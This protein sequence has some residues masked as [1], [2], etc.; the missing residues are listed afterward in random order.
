MQEP[1][2]TPDQP[3]D[4]PEALDVLQ[5]LQQPLDLSRVRRRPSPGSGTVPYLAGHDIITR[6][7]AIF[8]YAWSFEL[9]S[10]PVIER[11]QKQVMVWNTKEKRQVP[12]LD[13]AGRS[14]MER[15]G[16]VY[17]TG[18]VSVVLNGKLYTH[19]DVG[20]CPFIGDTTEALDT[21]LAGCATDCLKRCFR[22]LGEQFGN[23]LNSK[24]TS[25]PTRAKPARTAPVTVSPAIARHYTDGAKVNGNI[26]EQQAYDHFKQTTGEKPASKEALRNWLQS[27]RTQP[28]PAN[29]TK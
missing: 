3:N 25:R 5:K 24:E 18:K 2:E 28:Q 17:V 8:N 16:L 19:A 20:R 29:L 4:D 26:S 7:N 15:V 27:Q 12:A 6:A 11:W 10:Q 13:E 14:I 1:K 23:S 21:A 22:Q 9:L